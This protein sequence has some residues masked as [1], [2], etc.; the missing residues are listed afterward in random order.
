MKLTKSKLKQIIKE[1]LESAMFMDPPGGPKSITPEKAITAFNEWLQS[2]DQ[3]E[4]IAETILDQIA[5]LEAHHIPSF[6][7]VLS[8]GLYDNLDE[9]RHHVIKSTGA[10]EEEA[11]AFFDSIT[12]ESALKMAKDLETIR[13]LEVPEDMMDNY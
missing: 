6:Y 12:D 7:L 8:K 5:G 9:F 3:A 4:A 1:E 2:N 10:S 11:Q 13:G